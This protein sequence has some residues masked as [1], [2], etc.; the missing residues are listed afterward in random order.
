MRCLLILLFGLPVLL[1]A[2]EPAKSTA[3]PHSE[4]LRLVF[5]TQAQ[6][7]A[8]LDSPDRESWWFDT[9]VREWTVQRPFSPGY[10]DST[11]MFIVAYKIDG[12]VIAEWMVDTTAKTAKKQESPNQRPDGTPVKSPPSNPGQVSGVPHP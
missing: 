5:D 3:S 8:D 12:R 9:K 1:A 6:V 4:A 10:I 2:A 11:H 7:I